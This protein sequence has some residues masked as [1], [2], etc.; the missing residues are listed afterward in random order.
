MSDVFISYSRKDT[1]FVRK[2]HEALIAR[3]RDIWVDWEDIPAT[4]DWWKEIAGAIEATDTFIFVISPDSAR[5]EICRKEIEHALANNK[6]FVPIL[7]RPVDEAD[8]SLVHPAINTHNWIFFREGQ[9][10]DRAF[11]SLIAALDTDLS[12]VRQHTR[13]LVRAKEWD[14]SGKN[15]SFLLQG[16]DLKQAENWLTVSVAKKPAPT[17]LHASYITASRDAAVRRQRGLLAGVSVALVVALGLALLSFLLYGE[18]NVQRGIAEENAITATI[19]QG[20][21]YLE[22][23]RAGTQAAIAL[24]NAVTATIA[25]GEAEYQRATAEAN[26]AIAQREADANATAQANAQHEANNAATQAARAENNA[27]TAT[28]AQGE[29]ERQATIVAEERNRAQSIGISGQAQLEIVNEQPE[30][31]ILM[32]LYALENFPVTWQAEQALA[33]AVQDK[34]VTIQIPGSEAYLSVE[35]SPD[36]TRLLTGSA[37]DTARIWDVTTGAEQHRLRGHTGDVIRALWSPD[38]RYVATASIDSTARIWNADSGEQVALLSGH[39]A[40]LTSLDWSPDGRYLVTGSADNTAR[41]WDTTSG[42]Q[43][44]LLSGHTAP[45]NSVDWGNNGLVATGSA[46]HTVRIWTGEQGETVGAELITLSGHNAPVNRVSWSPSGGDLLSLSADGTGKMWQPSTLRVYQEKASLLGHFRNITD[47]AWSARGSR[48]VTVSQDDT[49]KIWGG[50]SG[51]QQ[52]TLYG[53]INDLRGVDWAPDGR[54]FVTVSDDATV[55]VWDAD[56]RATMLV[57]QG[58]ARPILDVDWSPDGTH[59]ATASTDGTVRLWQVW[60]DT[61]DLIEL[62][63]S[64]CVTRPLTDEESAQ[65]GFPPEPSAPRPETITSC[66]DTLPSRLYPGVRGQ[67]L[68]E[69]PRA[70][71]VRLAPRRNGQQIGQIAPR[72]TFWVVGEPVCEDGFA[73]FP[74]IFGINAVPGWIAEGDDTAY[75][76]RPVP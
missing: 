29:A 62:A 57:L 25:R 36:G 1:D 8:Q 44:A 13:L 15:P 54:R 47:A 30:R 34:L 17:P 66:P 74:I 63:K 32:V 41:I 26:A 60:R 64:C 23:D 49:A 9:D 69:D 4:A 67:V 35:F 33:L 3:E 71:N 52:F 45:V 42:E 5:S 12:H 27:A 28:Y 31:G 58:H 72:K 20:L 7:Y 61:S 59:I 10:F 2:L 37:D 40:A 48:I 11:D 56:S 68:D 50:R 76:V 16:D 55:R 73:W 6:R 14:S 24:N 43:I 19:A 39:S 22:A 75:Y 38:G 53:H 18:S 65:F 21:A 70:L 51:A 46:D